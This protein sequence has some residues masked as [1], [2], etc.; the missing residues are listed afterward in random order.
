MSPRPTPYRQEMSTKGSMEQMVRP[1]PRGKS[2]LGN[3]LS[4]VPMAI[5]MALSIS[6]RTVLWDLL[7]DIVVSSLK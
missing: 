4:M 5:M 2:I 1:P 6:Q 7:F 3:S